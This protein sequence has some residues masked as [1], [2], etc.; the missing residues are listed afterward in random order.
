MIVLKCAAL[1]LFTLA[2]LFAP[3]WYRL[4]YR[5]RYGSAYAELDSG[6]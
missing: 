3:S 5:I 6:R 1:I 4:Y 2:V